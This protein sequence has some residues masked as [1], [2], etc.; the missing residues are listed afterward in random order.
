MTWTRYIRFL[1]ARGQ[2]R[3]GNALVDSGDSLIEALQAGTL[4]AEELIGKDLF[5]A[6]R[7]GQVLRVHK[8]LG[9]LSAEDVPIIRAVGLNYVKHIQ[10]TG[11]KPP[12]YP[13]I[14]IKPSRT[15]TGWDS[16]VSVPSIAQKDQLDYEG[17]LAIVIGKE[18]KDIPAVDALDYIAGYAVANDVSARTWQRDPK[19]AGGVPQWCFSKG[20]D[21]FCPIGP[22]IVSPEVLG[23]AANLGLQ[24]RVNGEVRQDTSTGDLL[25]GVK[26]I[27]AFVSQGTTLEKGSVILTGTPGGVGMGL[28]PPNWLRDGDVVEVSIESIG[29]V[30]NK[31]VFAREP[32]NRR[33]VL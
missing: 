31:M 15:V 6:T 3:Q 11:R 5:S 13:S 2:P 29:T 4:A 17:E 27:V 23:P 33:T 8:L 24:T 16:D 10:E 1:D 32:G 30:R 21:T 7:T 28:S 14:F 19:F 25:F 22:M 9:P 18:G 12:P 26:E 20:F